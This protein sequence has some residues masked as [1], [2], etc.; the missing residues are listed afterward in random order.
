MSTVNEQPD[1]HSENTYVIDSTESSI[2]MAR[3]MRQDLL[4]TQ[5]MGGL[6]PEQ[7]DL[8]DVHDILDIACGPGGWVIETAYAHSDIEVTGV[9]ISEKMINYARAQANVQHL[10]NAHFQVM[11][12]FKPLDFPDA[13]FDLINTRLIVAFML[14][15][16]WP[17]FLKECMRV[18]RPGG[19]MRC[20]DAEWGLGNGAAFEKYSGLI[21]QA[22]H[23]AGQSFSPNGMHLGLIPVMPRLFQ[24]AGYQ[25][26]G[27]M[28]HMIDFSHGTELNEGFYHD[29]SSV[30]KQIQPFMVKY[31]VITP[32]EVE[33]LYQQALADMLAEDF[34]GC[35][36]LLTVWGNKP[37]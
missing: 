10:D 11:N 14:P 8:S 1:G 26:I 7:T 35:W 36:I 28:A 9:D 25:Q 31:N 2:E 15:E 27:R 24:D 22:L 21:T 5:G 20:T 23:R 30:F 32:A 19:I 16:I 34:C 6:F 4:L 12:A 3:L 29:L 33:I 13:S 18:L 37:A 17:R